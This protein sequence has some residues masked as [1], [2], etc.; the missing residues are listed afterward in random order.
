MPMSPDFTK[1]A[2]NAED[3]NNV[4]FND[5]LEIHSIY[6]KRPKLRQLFSDSRALRCAVNLDTEE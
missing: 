1:H 4:D 6:G 2:N 5:D 3:A